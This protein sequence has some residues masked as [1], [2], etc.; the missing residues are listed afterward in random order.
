MGFLV[1]DIPSR[2][3]NQNFYKEKRIKTFYI[4]ELN[5]YHIAEISFNGVPHSSE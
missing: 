3:S 4:A 2:Q 5:V 1:G